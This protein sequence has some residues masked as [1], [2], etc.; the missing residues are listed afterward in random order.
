MREALERQD[1]Q[2]MD[3]ETGDEGRKMGDG[4]EGGD[5]RKRIY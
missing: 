4:V 2:D 1:T 3:E 5:G